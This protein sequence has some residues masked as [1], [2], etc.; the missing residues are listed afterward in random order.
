VRELKVILCK[1]AGE[2]L[3]AF[4]WAE[5]EG[6]SLPGRAHAEVAVTPERAEGGNSFSGFGIDRDFQL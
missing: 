5:A 2:K 6:Y 3:T 1:K 4:S